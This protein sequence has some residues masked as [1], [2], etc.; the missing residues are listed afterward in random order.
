MEACELL[1]LL[2]YT[3]YLSLRIQGQALMP[4]PPAPSPAAE[5]LHLLQIRLVCALRERTVGVR[6]GCAG[7][8]R[9]VT[10]NTIGNLY[11]SMVSVVLA[12]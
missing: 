1:S 12:S 10:A 2:L 5:L 11:A 7:P 9:P 3:L 6:D 8:E 4:E